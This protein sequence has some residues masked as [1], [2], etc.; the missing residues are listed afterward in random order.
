MDIALTAA[1]VALIGIALR[2]IFETLFRPTGS[3][4]VGHGIVRGVWRVAH[5]TSRGRAGGPLYAGPLGYLAV[6]ASWTAMLVIGWA[7]VF[8]PHMPEGFNFAA[9]VEPSEQDSFAD[10]LYLSLVNLTSLG[11]GDISPASPGMR[12]LAP[13]ET[14]FGLGLVTASISWLLSI[15]GALRRRETLAHEVHLLRE[16]E[17]RID[18]DLIRADPELLERMLASFLEKLIATRRDLIH[19]PITHYFQSADERAYRDELRSFLRRLAS[20]A[21][22]ERGPRALRIRAEILA[23]ALD[24]YERTLLGDSEPRTADR[25]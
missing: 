24:D 1:G 14:V 8:M 4:A 12:V 17:Q 6:L 22:G 18:T 10:A 15:Y 11:Y 13:V 19:M 9:G 2:D 20:E 25:R 16:V 23:L 3:G 5:W 21:S 7:L